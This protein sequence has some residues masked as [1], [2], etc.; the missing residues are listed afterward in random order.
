[1][2]VWAGQVWY[3]FLNIEADRNIT[4]R[5]CVLWSIVVLRSV[6]VKEFSFLFDLGYRHHREDYGYETSDSF[7]CIGENSVLHS[8]IVIRYDIRFEYVDL[9]L[10]KNNKI[11]LQ[12]MDGFAVIKGYQFNDFEEY[13][14]KSRS[15]RESFRSR[16]RYNG[17]E[18]RMELF[19]ECALFLKKN[20]AFLLDK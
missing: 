9:E 5:N 19:N 8:L 10:K 2:L 6:D 3:N 15:I 16:K 7:K 20:I 14:S 4:E 12:I 13:M 17:E 1:M 11:A 18:L